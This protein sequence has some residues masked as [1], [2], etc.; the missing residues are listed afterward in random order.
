MR[1]RRRST[2]P[3][4]R[5]RHHFDRP[6]PAS[7]CSSSIG[8]TGR[9]VDQVD[10]D[11]AVP[12]LEEPALGRSLRPHARLARAPPARARRAPRGRRSRR[13]GRSAGR[14]APRPRA[15]RR[16]SPAHPPR[17]ARP[18]RSSSSR[19]ARGTFSLGVYPMRRRRTRRAGP[20]FAEPRSR[21]AAAGTWHRG[22]ESA[23]PPRV[24]CTASEEHRER[25]DR[26]L[27][28]RR[29]SAPTCAARGRPH[30]ATGCAEQA[31]VLA[32]ACR[33][34]ARSP[35]LA[36]L[37][38]HDHHAGRCGRGRGDPRATPA[39]SSSTAPTPDPRARRA[40]RSASS[41]ARASSAG[42]PAR[43]SRTS[44]SRSCVRSTR[45]RRSRSLRSSRASRRSP[46]ATAGSSCCTTRRSPRRSSGSRS[47]SGRF[48][49]RAGS[50]GRSARTGPTPCSTAT[51]TTAGHDGAIG[52]V[53]V[54]N[55]ARHV[56]EGEF[57]VTRL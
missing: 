28:G 23:S 7:N 12:G 14:R 53:P 36:V 17:R 35:V 15:R 52:E 20:D 25:L 40:S 24:T 2:R 44:A 55:V 49:A 11:V 30:D 46:A 19:S 6:L 27:R 16:A 47:G 18:P 10:E 13:R 42:S 32:D 8:A 54:K 26:R 45:R 3:R 56:I 21:V 39:S 37:G 31:A 43:R 1:A 9:P 33:R 57:L 51:R 50:P 41:A 4:A 29:P 48:S 22:S 38:N 5:L 34:P